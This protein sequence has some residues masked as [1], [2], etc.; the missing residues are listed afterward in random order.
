M[1]AGACGPD[2]ST[3]EI[4]MPNPGRGFVEI[5]M[6]FISRSSWR[7]TPSYIPSR[8]SPIVH[9]QSSIPRQQPYAG[10]P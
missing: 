6:T 3:P 8:P 5:R 1:T 9:P 4:S 7:H 2:R 10:A